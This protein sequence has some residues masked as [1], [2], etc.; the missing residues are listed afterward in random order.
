MHL[1]WRVVW[2]E[3]WN[4]DRCYSPPPFLKHRYGNRQ[5]FPKPTAGKELHYSLCTLSAPSSASQLTEC[6][7][8]EKEFHWICP[9]FTLKRI[10]IVTHDRDKFR[11]SLQVVQL[12]RQP[13]QV[14]FDC[15]G[16]GVSAQ[17]FYPIY[18]R[19]RMWDRHIS[20]DLFSCRT[21]KCQGELLWLKP[22][23]RMQRALILT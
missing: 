1:E 11:Y 12:H 15:I 19:R 20:E 6:D 16:K 9:L 8:S 21:H 14:C 7:Q 13:S 22:H 10:P 18:R 5:T 4:L 23:W 2:S 3:E 17:V